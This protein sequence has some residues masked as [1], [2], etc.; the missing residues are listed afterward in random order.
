MARPEGTPTDPVS[1]RLF[2]DDAAEPFAEYRPPAIVDLDTMRLPDGR[3]ALRV[4]AVDALGHVGVRTIPFEV[5]NGPG[6]TIT[7]LRPGERVSGTLSLDV[8]A[9]SGS[10][11]FDPVRAESSGPIP[12]W[13]WVMIALIAAWAGWY[14]IAEF[15]TP[16]AFAATPTYESNPVEAANAPLQANAPPSYSGRGVA[17]GFDYAK[18][19]PNLYAANCAACHGATGSGVL[20]AF[21]PLAADGV[22]T[23]KNPEEHIE[24]VFH[25]LH[26]KS[27]GG[28]SYSSQMPSFAQLSDDDIAAIIDHERTSWG[29]NAPI[30]TPDEVRRARR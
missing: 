29:N 27:I 18:T 30:I 11:P 15:P 3:H 1:I 26:G 2:L 16:P 10:E 6:I 21:P 8:N 17:A 12:V 20:G 9:F 25:G 23:A 24:I 13:T 7:G 14:A 22:V 28:K 4:E 19:G 5:Q